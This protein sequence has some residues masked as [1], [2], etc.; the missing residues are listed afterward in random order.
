MNFRNETIESLA[1]KCKKLTEQVNYLQECIK[2]MNSK[3][4][5][6][7]CGAHFLNDSTL[8]IH[9]QEHIKNIYK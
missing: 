9:E 3:K 4:T 5:C 8:N 6:Q 7:F 2:N 1:E